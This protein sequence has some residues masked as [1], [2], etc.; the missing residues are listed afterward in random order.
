[1]LYS[2]IEYLDLP[3][4][5]DVVYRISIYRLWSNNDT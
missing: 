3:E 4:Q 1:M 2:L 5:K